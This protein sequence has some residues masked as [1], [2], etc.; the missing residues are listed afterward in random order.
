VALTVLNEVIT[1]AREGGMG[2]RGV[3]SFL[4]FAVEVIEAWGYRYAHFD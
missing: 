2:D 1:A 3:G 4:A